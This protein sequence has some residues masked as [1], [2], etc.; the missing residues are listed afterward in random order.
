[1]PVCILMGE[2]KRMGLGV[3]G[4]EEGQGG[5]RDGEIVSE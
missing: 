4:S 1:V 5:A 2:R 3:W